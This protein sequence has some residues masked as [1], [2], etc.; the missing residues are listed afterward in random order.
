MTL[1]ITPRFNL[2]V[3]QDFQRIVAQRRRFALPELWNV[4]TPRRRK[5][6]SQKEVLTNLRGTT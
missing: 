1:E 2:G 3:A 6:G 5:L 4:H